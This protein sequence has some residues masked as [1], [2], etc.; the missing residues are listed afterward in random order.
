MNI[1]TQIENLVG[2]ARDEVERVRRPLESAFTLPP[3]AY[4]SEEIYQA[5]IDNIMRKSWMP[6][7]R[8]D[9]VPNPGDYI[10]MDILDQPVVVVHGHDGEIRVLSRVCLHRAAP[11]VE[12]SGN[13]KLFSCPYHAWS[14][15]TTG[16]LVRAPMMEGAEGFS[17]SA[18]KLPQIRTEIWEGFILA[19]LN[20]DCDPFAPQVES[21]RKYF[22]KFKL[23]EMVVAR[24][25]EFESPWNWKVL[26][27]NFME[28]YHH[29]ATH[30]KTLEQIYHAADSTVPDNDG[31]W[32]ILHM[33]SEHDHQGVLP[34]VDGLEDWQERDLFANVLFP[35]FLFAV[36]GTALTWYQVFPDSVDKF[37]L[38]IHLCFPK[39][40]FEIDGFEEAADAAAELV[41]LIHQEDIG[42]ND[43]VWSGLNAQLTRQGRLAPFEKSIW[44]LNQW[45]LDRMQGL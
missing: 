11:I 15:D 45:W 44:Q 17:A 42:A 34:A 32:S 13:R 31:P 10:A 29:I 2:I 37:L 24:T 22:E 27:E 16:Q 23:S 35:H 4:T 28:A 12:G 14:Y 39:S 6:L 30:S 1:S 3:L 21:F 9:Q 26:V 20:A 8:V 43:L 40:S 41:Q 38:K 18:C 25:V 5:E 33:P 36:Q 19:N 7:A